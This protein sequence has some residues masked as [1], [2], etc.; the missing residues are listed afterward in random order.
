MQKGQ[1]LIWIIVGSLVIALAGGAYYLGRSTSPKPSTP[2][3]TSPTPQP[4]QTTS[5]NKSTLIPIKENT[6]NFATIN[7]QI[8][9]KYHNKVYDGSNQFQMDP[10]NI[11][12][13]VSYT[14]YGLVDA[15]SYVDGAR[16]QGG[17]WDE[18]FSFKALPN[19][20]DFI[21]IMRW[22]K[23]LAD[24]K[25]STQIFP[26]YLYTDN[27]K[28]IK[29][30]ITFESSFGTSEY[31]FP[32]IDQISKDG[33]YIDFDMY[34]CWNCGGHKPEELL[35]N[36]E[37]SVTKRIGKVLLFNWRDNGQYEYKDYKVIECKELT[38]GECTENPANLPLKTGQF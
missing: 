14:W 24:N 36:L 34:G 21:F 30:I 32:K 27:D 7:N 23:P 37:T 33:K 4:T 22:S 5:V 8:Y 20:K 31:N 2:T 1:I 28:K 35:M 16:K 38:P 10:V 9:L 25:G 6:V 26:I 17:A 15:P 11:P 18:L 19:D 13:P 3:V 12:N 29:N